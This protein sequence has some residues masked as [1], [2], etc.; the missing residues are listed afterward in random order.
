LKE[1]F[2]KASDWEREDEWYN[3]MLQNLKSAKDRSNL[4]DSVSTTKIIPIYRRHSSHLL[5]QQTEGNDLEG[6][7]MS[8]LKSGQEDKYQ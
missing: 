3:Q 1:K 2:P 6:I 7:I 5:C 4:Q 8:L